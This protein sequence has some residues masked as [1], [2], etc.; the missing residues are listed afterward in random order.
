MAYANQSY[1]GNVNIGSTST[2]STSGSNNVRR[3]SSNA[4]PMVSSAS[5]LS[6]ANKENKS[7]LFSVD[8][9]FQQTRRFY[10]TIE[11]SHEE[12]RVGWN[13]EREG[14]Q[15]ERRKLLERIDQ[16]ESDVVNVMRGGHAVSGRNT[17]QQSNQMTNQSISGLPP[18]ET[19]TSRA[20]W[21]GP[22]SLPT[23]TFSEPVGIHDST[24]HSDRL[25]S[26]AEHLDDNER[27]RSVDFNLGQPS[28]SSR[29]TLVT[30]I[31]GELIH[32]NNSGITL[33]STAVPLEFRKAT[34][35]AVVCSSP[36]NESFS[37][38]ASIPQPTNRPMLLDIPTANMQSEDLY[39]R[40]AG[41][42]PMVRLTG[43]EDSTGTV[44]PITTEAAAHPPLEPHTTE[45]ILR[46]P[47]E[48]QDSYFVNA[49]ADGT[50][51]ADQDPALREPLGVSADNTDADVNFLNQ[52]NE[53]L[54]KG[55]TNQTQNPEASPSVESTAPAPPARV[56]NRGL[57]EVIDDFPK[58]RMRAS[59]NFGAPFG[60]PSHQ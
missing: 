3:P 31:P 57:S 20:V 28:G 33:R 21:Q 59:C 56:H 24:P 30:G 50:L 26:I 44:T 19:S 1:P 47:N 55:L 16:L 38:M 9:I 14:W 12:E 53:A 13:R 52:V 37:P 41:H 40:H 11:R 46:P 4:Q 15:K 23:R 7:S 58:L 29:H 54:R 2:P 45:T 34:G 27:K 36:S 10:Q 32:L 60:E 18:A 48:R 51:S 42:T 25:N 22:E 35:E 6:G 39:S 49:Q 5:P 43:G 8:Q 17:T